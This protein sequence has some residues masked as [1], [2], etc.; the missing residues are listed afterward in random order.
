VQSFPTGSYSLSL[1][2]RNVERIQPQCGPGYGYSVFASKSN[3]SRLYDPRSITY[4]RAHFCVGDWVYVEFGYTDNVLR[5]G[6]F[7]QS[8]FDPSVSWS[9]MPS[10][11]LDGGRQG[12]VTSDTT[13][14]NGP[15]WNCGDY[16]SCVLYSGTRVTACME[17]NGWYFCRFY[18]D[19][20]NNYGTIYLW[21]YGGN[22]RW[23]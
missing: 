6:F 14:Y 17:C 23:Q 2:N 16:P 11:S 12:Y 13:P 21:V 15:G 22:I 20:H 7:E 18:N 9:S 1:R 8:L 19:P 5:Y 3:G 4:M 10:C